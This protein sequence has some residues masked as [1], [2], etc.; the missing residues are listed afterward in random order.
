[1]RGMPL[2]ACLDDTKLTT[3]LDSGC[4]HTVHSQGADHLTFAGAGGGG[5]V[6]WVWVISEENFLRTD[7][8]GKVETLLQSVFEFI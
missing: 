6:R 2:H 1:M 7:F 4:Q 3:E 8:E 5:G